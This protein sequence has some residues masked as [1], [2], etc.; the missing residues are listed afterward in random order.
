MC[1]LL[2]L[3]V[4]ESL[5]AMGPE[6]AS[7]LLPLIAAESDLANTQSTASVSLRSR[8]GSSRGASRGPPS[9][10]S[11]PGAVQMSNWSEREFGGAGG[12]GSHIGMPRVRQ[13]YGGGF[14]GRSTKRLPAPP[15]LGAAF[16]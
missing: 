2:V 16:D 9:R 14:V 3:Q 15:V 8:G 7:K 10:G 11:T 5:Y 12:K 4:M 6:A 13:G 1:G